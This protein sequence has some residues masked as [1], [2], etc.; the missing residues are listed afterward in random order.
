[1]HDTT[2]MFSGIQFVVFEL[3]SSLLGFVLFS[4]MSFELSAVL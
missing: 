4:F 2:V 3:F 1:M